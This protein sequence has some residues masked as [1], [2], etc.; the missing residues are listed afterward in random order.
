MKPYFHKA[1]HFTPNPDYDIDVS[2]RPSPPFLELYELS[3]E[4]LIWSRNEVVEGSGRP[5]IHLLTLHLRL[6]SRRG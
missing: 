4:R 1:E 2:V 6:C 3:E 5:V